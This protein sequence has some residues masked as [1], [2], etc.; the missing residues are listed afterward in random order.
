MA[1][2]DSI[3]FWAII[4]CI[5]LFVLVRAAAYF[6]TAAEKIGLS[7]GFSPFVVGVLIVAFGTSLPELISSVISVIKDA[8]EIVTGN[9]MGSNITNIFLVFGLAL[10]INQKPI[11]IDSDKLKVDLN[12]LLGT[13]LFLVFTAIDGKFNFWEG[14][15]CMVGFIVYILHLARG[16][17]VKKKAQK[18]E[19][20]AGNGLTK[21]Y[22]IFALSGA[23]IYFGAEYTITSVI[24]IS[25]HFT[26]GRDVIAASAIAL[27]TSL[28]ELIVTIVAVRQ[29]KTDIAVGN[30]LGSSVFNAFW[31]MGFSSMFGDI[32]V[33]QSSLYILAPFMLIA[34][35]L[36]FFMCKNKEI[37]V[38]EGGLLLVFY[39]LFAAKLFDIF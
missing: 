12:F 33:T 9:V 10:V 18:V 4:L 13:A 29:G 19:A 25:D 39:A 23:L 24:K 1:F 7:F 17:K 37:G 16:P 2:T 5:S 34:T 30:I 20:K 28:P 15:L 38:W 36:Y 32:I 27:G 31:V 21:Q 22:V 11:H 14:M 3:L 8:S 26:I 6:N 35:F